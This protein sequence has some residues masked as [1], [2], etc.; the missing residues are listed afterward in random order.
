MSPPTRSPLAVTCG[1]TNCGSEVPVANRRHSFL[2][3]TGTLPGLGGACRSCG[4]NTVDW[5]LCH[6]KDPTLVDELVAQMRQELIRDA[7]WSAPLPEHVRRLALRREPTELRASHRRLLERELRPPESANPFLRMHTY[8]GYKPAA[9]IIHCAQ[10]ATGSCCRRCLEKWHGIP[11][12]Q[13]LSSAELGYLEGLTWL[14]TSARLTESA[15][16]VDLAAA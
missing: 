3:T 5:A 11:R 13:A 6:A 10:H 1:Q 2:E 16:E 7:Y 12:E 8:Y 4:T 14:Y 9:R 15:A